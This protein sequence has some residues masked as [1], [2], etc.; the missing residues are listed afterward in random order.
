MT[1]L[2][3][4][5]VKGTC[6]VTEQEYLHAV[7]HRVMRQTPDGTCEQVGPCSLFGLV[8]CVLYVADQDAVK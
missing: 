1:V 7:P 3:E 8:R 5:V 6:D 2:C 4:K